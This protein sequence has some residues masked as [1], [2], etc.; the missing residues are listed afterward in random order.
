V[1]NPASAIGTIK[2][3]S[4]QSIFLKKFSIILF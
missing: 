1:I 2:K 3:K 4:S